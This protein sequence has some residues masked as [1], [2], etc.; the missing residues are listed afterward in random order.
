MELILKDSEADPVRMAFPA[1]YEPK[2]IGN[3]PTSKPAYGARYI[4]MPG[5][6]N[7][8]ALAAAVKAVAEEKWPGKSANILKQLYADK[9]VC[10]VEGPYLNKDGEPYEG[11][12]DM[13]NLG[14]RNEKLKP[15]VKDRF[16]QTVKEGDPGA[17]Y[18]GCHVHAAVEV[19]AQDNQWGRR[20]NATT[21]GVMF[22]RDGGAFSGGRPASDST[23]AELAAEP[24]AEDFV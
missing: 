14:T 7:A 21:N 22:S 17:P 11:F 16:N 8:K 2:A 4:I 6:A 20:I 12:E 5:G 15:T 1:I 19:W 9:K 23:F 3:D 13:Y 24:S 10:F 18:A